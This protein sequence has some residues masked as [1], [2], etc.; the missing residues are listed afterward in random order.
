MLCGMS[1]KP[2]CLPKLRIFPLDFTCSLLEQ[3]KINAKKY[4]LRT[5]KGSFLDARTFDLKIDRI[6]HGRRFR[7]NGNGAWSICF[8]TPHADGLSGSLGTLNVKGL[9]GGG[10]FA[11]Q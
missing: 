9:I 4:A 2:M 10:N 1:A 6:D 3:L 8:E 7:S 11:A 5:L